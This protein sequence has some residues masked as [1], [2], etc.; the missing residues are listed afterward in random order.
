MVGEVLLLI[1]F[2][3]WTEKHQG[4]ALH[5]TPPPSLML[6]PS[7]LLLLVPSSL[8]PVGGCGTAPPKLWGFGS[9]EVRI[10]LWVAGKLFENEVE[11]T[12]AEG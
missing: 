11:Q 6:L 12:T 3:L 2:V 7:L 10:E 9:D 5:P 1:M 8:I 4:D